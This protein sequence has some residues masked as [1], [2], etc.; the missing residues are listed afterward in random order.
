MHAVHVSI[1]FDW[2][3]MLEWST[4]LSGVPF[5]IKRLVWIFCMQ[6]MCTFL[7]LYF[8]LKILFINFKASS[9]WNL[10]NNPCLI[11][12]WCVN[13]A[14]SI[15]ILL[16]VGISSCLIYKLEK[17][18]NEWFQA[19]PLLLPGTLEIHSWNPQAFGIP[20]NEAPL[21]L[22]ILSFHLWYRYGY[23][24]VGLVVYYLTY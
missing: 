22:R 14:L 1:R 15:F 20:G 21:S 4:N 17:W 6:G 13:A 2:L 18:T 5:R 19:K 16:A 10:L 12:F 8:W 9:I 3:P 7:Y 11:N 24:Q 23:F